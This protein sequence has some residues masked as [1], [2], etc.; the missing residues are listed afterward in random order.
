MAFQLYIVED[1]I[2]KKTLSTKSHLPWMNT[3]LKWL[4]KKKQWT[5]NHAKKYKENWDEY[6]S[7]KWQSK[8]IVHRQC[9]QYLSNLIDWQDNS[10]NLKCYWHCV[11]GKCRDNVEIGELKNQ[12]NDMVAESTGKAEI[13]SKQFKLVFTIKDTSTI[14]SLL[15]VSKELFLMVQVLL[16]AVW[17]Q[18]SHKD[19]C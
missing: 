15:T 14:P 8:S 16:P 2:P 12:A 18:E 17:H 10:N 3:I 6:K 1:N 7:L 4:L 11:K 19:H 13:L 5:Y 9:K